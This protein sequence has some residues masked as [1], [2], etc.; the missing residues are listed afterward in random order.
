MASLADKAILSGAENRPPMLEK[1]MYDSSRSRMELYMLN[2]QHG[3]MILESIEHGPLHWTSVTKDGVTRLKKYFELSSTEATQADCDVKATNIILQA[4]LLEIYALVSTHK[5]AKDLW[6]WI[7]M[8]MQGTLLTKQERE[9]KL[10]D[11]FDKF[12]Y[13]KGETL[14]DFYLKFSLLLN[15]LN[16]YNMKLEQFQVNTKF[17]NTLPPKWS[18]FVTDVKLFVSQGSSSSNLSI[19]Y[20][21]NDTSSTVNHNAYMASAPQIDYTLIANHPSEFSSPE[22]GLVVLVF[23]KGDDPIDAINH[24]MS[25]LTSVV[26]SRYPATNNQLQTSSN[27]R[28][29]ATINDGRVTIQPI[30][31]RQNHMLAGLSRPFAS[32]YGGTSGRQRV[33]V[34]YNYKGEAHMAKQC[35]KPKRKRDADWFKDKV[36]L[37]QAQANGQVMQ[38]EE[39]DFLADLGTAESS[40]NQSV[41]TKNAAYQADD[42]DAYVL[43]CDELNS[44]K[45]ALMENLSHY[46]S[47]NLA[48]ALGFQNPC[49]LKK[50]QQ[51]KPKLYDGCVIEKS[52][53]IMVPDIEETLMLAKES[54]Q[55]DE[56]NLSGTPKVSMVNSCLKK[57]KFHLASF[58]TI[59]KKRTTATAIT[60]GTWGFKHTKACF[61]DD[62]ISFVK[63]LKELFTSFDQ[64]LIDEVTEVQNVFTQMEL[65]VEQQ[66]E[67][68]TKVQIK[69]EN[70]LQEN[71]RLLTQALSVEIVN[72]VVHEN[73]KS[74]YL[75]VTACSRCVTTESELKM[76]FLNNECYDTLLQK[77]HTLE[78]HCITL[79]VNN[80][81][82]TKIFQRDTWSSQESALTFAELFE[83]NNLKAQAREKDTVILKLKEKLNSLN[84]DVNDRHVKRDIEEIETLNIELDHKVTKLAVE[85]EHLKQTYKQLYD[86]VKYSRVRSK[87]Q[88]KFEAKGYE[89]YFIGYSMSSKAFRVFNKRTR[90]V[91]ENLHVEFLENKAIEKGAGPNWLFDI[92]SLTKSMNY[93]PV[94]ADTNSTKFS[95]TKDGT[96]QEVKKD[97]SSLRY[98]AVPNWAHDVLLESSSSKPYDESN[99][100]VLEGSGNPNPNA[101]SSNPPADQ[102]D[103]LI[104]ESP[105]PTDSSPV[106]T[107]C[108]N[109]S[110]EPSNEARLILKRVANQEKTPSLDNILSLTN[111]FEYILR[112]TTSSDEAIGVEADVSNMETTISASP[113]PTLRIHKDHPKKPKKVSNSLQDPSWVE[114]MQEELLQFKIKNFWTLVNCPKGVR[115]IR[116]KWVLKNKKD[117][118]GIVVRNKA[119]LVAQGQTQEEGIDYDEVFAPVARIEAIRLFLAYA[120]FMGFTVEFEA[121]MHEKFQMSAMGELNF[122]LGLQVLQKEDGIFLSQDKYIGDILKKFGYSDVR[123]LN[124]PMDK[125]NPW[126]KDGT[127]K[128]V[129]LHLYRSMIGSLMYLTASKPDIMF[130]GHPK[131]SLWYPKE[132]PFDLVAYSDSDY[133]GASQDRKSTTG[134]STK[135]GAIQE[136]KK[137][138]SSLR[139]IA[140]PNWAHDALLESSSSKPHDE[141]NTKLPEGSGNPNPTASSSNPPSDQMDTLTVESLIPTDSSPV[142]TAYLNDSSEPSS[143]ARLISKRVANQEETPSLDNILLLTNRFEDILRVTTSSDE[144]IGVEADMD[145]KSAFLYGTIDEED[146]A[147]LAKAYKVE[148]AMYGLHQAPR[149]WYG[150]LSK[151][152]LMNGFQWGTIDQALFIRR[153]RGNFILVQVY[154]D[155][156]IF[157]SSN[158]QL[159]REFEAL[160]H[161]KFQMSA[162]GE[163]NFFLGLQVLQKEDV[164]FLS[165]DKYGKDGTGKDVDLLLYRSMIGS[166]MYLTASRPDI[167]FAIC[168]CARH[169][170]TPKECRLHAV[171]RIFRYLK[172]HPKLGLWYPKDSLFDLVAYSDSDYGGASQDR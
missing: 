107:T 70:V 93:V 20:P 53:A 82:N 13:Q 95:G 159:C 57:L 120:S 62:I 147:F 21:M 151:Y 38:K 124:T 133:G 12:A 36:L 97:V 59:V 24:M 86:S 138:V 112:V 108:L 55:T 6:E 28:H 42:L 60:E 91:E 122:F 80:Q 15:D 45:V 10:Y 92:D 165:Q 163:L 116:T 5:V 157:G 131:L 99:T 2:R 152:L 71:N 1:D 3:R 142:P 160:L 125:E 94:D 100:K 96:N 168:A 77:Y 44:A 162:M 109:D 69:M 135:D 146:P 164:I 40:T 170:V 105:I 16:M 155:D 26:T 56:P 48:E 106:L 14:R 88:W 9:C 78:K 121:L 63:S 35:T 22:T 158:P 49:Y 34:C 58:D 87:K 47:N 104:V 126:G 33:I 19:S 29:Q 89:G 115:P 66:C 37:V 137:D 27:P 65:A 81:L 7:E 50:A 4:L 171:K 127:G 140:L 148:K 149:A 123:S 61:C 145:V 114:A 83:I 79:E 156:I 72:I 166:L 32:G 18:K 169:Q 46:G 54:L 23:Q 31:R 43:D 111:R 172:G 118:R 143:E 144:A 76:D 136:V 102:M 129:D 150:T 101:S 11:A 117:K 153:Q 75:N 52:E 73:M 8:L 154:V 134:G 25:F 74:V 84:G 119:R 130:A 51:L 67:E 90:R 68:K 64:C 141:S 128:D 85:N 17:L 39:L 30:Q 41:V 110:P 103:T 132:S 161:E 113:T 167:M 98:I 139:Y